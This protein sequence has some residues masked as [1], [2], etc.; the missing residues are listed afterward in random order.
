MLG[1]C[2]PIKTIIAWHDNMHS[3]EL[4][5]IRV[6]VVDDHPA[7]RDGLRGYIDAEPDMVVIGEAAD[8][9]EA[10]EAFLQWRPDVTLMDLQMPACGG[11]YGINAIRTHDSNAA[12]VVLTTFAGD[13][14][15]K[16]AIER[17]A[18]ACLLKSAPAEV[19]VEAI[20]AAAAGKRTAVRKKAQDP[21]RLREDAKL[22]ARELDIVRCLV[23]GCSNPDIASRLHISEQTVKTHIKHILQKLDARDRTH[24]VS[25][26]AERGYLDP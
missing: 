16:L 22:S 14:R 25:V 3:S 11:I 18:A 7:M 23:E 1:L 17:G 26:A 5:K 13:E 6:L 10:L 4:K 12:I 19:I 21:G 8:G 20:R 9:C 2:F 15:A 24:A